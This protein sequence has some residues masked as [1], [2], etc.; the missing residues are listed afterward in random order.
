M[1]QGTDP[2]FKPQYTK[3]ER[4]REREN[5]VTKKFIILLYKIMK[6]KKQLSKVW[7]CILVISALRR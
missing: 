4:E 5:L 1:A 6:N 2:E 3:K 7:W